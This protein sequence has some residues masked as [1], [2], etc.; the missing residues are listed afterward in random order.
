MQHRRREV[1]LVEYEAVIGLEVHAELC[2]ASKVFCGCATTF[3][4]PPNNQVCPVCLGLPGALPALN[5]RA[6]EYAIAAGLA[7]NCQIAST[8]QFDRKQYY[9]PDLPKAYQI[10]QYH[11]PLCTGGCLE[12][13]TKQGLKRVGITRIHLEEEAGKTVH[14]GSTGI[15][16]A[17]YALIDYNRCGIPLIEIVSGPDLRF[18]EEAKLFL[19][20]LRSILCYLGV[21]DGKMEEGSL[22]CD[23][24]VS[25][26]PVGEQAMGKRA[27]IKNLNS[28]RAV[29]AALAYEIRRQMELA[30]SGTPLAMEEA[31]AWDEQSGMTVYMRPKEQPHEYRYYPDPDLMPVVISSAW[32]EEIGRTIPELPD[33]K[34]DRYTRQWGLASHDAWLIAAEQKL[35]A[36]FEAV[37]ESFSGNPKTVSH[38]VLGE[39]SRLLNLE[40]TAIDA[41]KIRP[42]DFAVL[43]E[44]LAAGTVSGNT[45]KTVLETMFYTGQDPDTIIREQGLAQISDV[46]QLQELVAAVLAAHPGP[47]ADYRA[48]KAK[49]FD[50]LVGQVMKAT[51]GRANPEVVRQILIAELVPAE[52]PAKQ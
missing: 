23:A 29:Q 13:M 19:E 42:R 2:T 32:V 24:N 16:G 21:S 5:R 39:F 26:R 36:Y 1:G 38:W 25:V 11:Q 47:V 35:A 20:K 3:G 17:Q 48:G 15:T 12:I 8:C 41:V 27:E 6:L 18:P 22:R 33:A 31:R 30:A 50:Y 10:T 4:A 34:Y 14:A 49:A 51:R 40:K 43:L 7:L 9:Y 28:F 52:K 46:Q 44:R 37:V 45:A